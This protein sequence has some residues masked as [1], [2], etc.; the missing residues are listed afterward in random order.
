MSREIANRYAELQTS[1]G[2]NWNYNPGQ[3]AVSLEIILPK[4]EMENALYAAAHCATADEGR[5]HLQLAI[6]EALKQFAA[7]VPTVAQS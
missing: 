3:D 7:Q 2:I 4:E 1:S 5:R 6:R